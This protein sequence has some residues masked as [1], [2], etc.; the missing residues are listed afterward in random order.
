MCDKNICDEICIKIELPLFT[1]NT[2]ESCT[3]LL[4]LPITSLYEL[5]A[6]YVLGLHDRLHDGYMGH[7]RLHMT[8]VCTS[9]VIYVGYVYHKS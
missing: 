9:T 7:G 4:G 3:V 2:S 1:A 6:S 8:V 5:H